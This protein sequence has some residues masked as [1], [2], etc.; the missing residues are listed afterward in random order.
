MGNR[1]TV[2]DDR[3]ITSSASSYLFCK[4]R[5][6]SNTT[7]NLYRGHPGRPIVKVTT[8]RNSEFHKAVRDNHEDT[9]YNVTLIGLTVVGLLAVTPRFRHRVIAYDEPDAVFD[10][11]GSVRV[12]ERLNI[13]QEYTVKFSYDSSDR[14]IAEEVHQ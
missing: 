7:F 8:T 1:S 3:D 2:T 14:M 13:G 12:S 9:Y 4:I 10:I 6:T 5:I 11:I